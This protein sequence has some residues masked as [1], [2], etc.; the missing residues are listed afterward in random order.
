MTNDIRLLLLA[1]WLGAAMFFSAVVAPT[2]FAVLR[3]YMLPNA[4]EIAGTII[5]RA[6]AVVNLS[7]FIGSVVLLL[8]A[9]LVKRATRLFLLELISLAV[10]AIATGVGQWVI[11]A[12]LHSLRAAMVLPI[13]QIPPTDPGRIAF[14]NLHKY[15]V[16]ALAIAMIAALI[17][18]FVIAHRARVN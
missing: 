6:L 15:S 11:A 8:M 4:G 14:N 17:A 3:A 2:T 13:D 18:F 9:L 5:N 12:R 1:L 16:T 10:V 7:G